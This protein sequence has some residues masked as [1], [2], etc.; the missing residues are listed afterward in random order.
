MS[1]PS[2]YLDY[3]PHFGIEN[4]DQVHQLPVPREI[5][6]ALAETIHRN[7]NIE[8]END[9]PKYRDM[10]WL[11]LGM[12]IF[13]VCLSIRFLSKVTRFSLATI[14]LTLIVIK[15]FMIMTSLPLKERLI[16]VFLAQVKFRT[17][18]VVSVKEV[19]EYRVKVKNKKGQMSIEEFETLVGFHFSVHKHNLKKFNKQSEAKGDSLLVHDNEE[20]V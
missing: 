18:G 5:R 14:V 7:L 13:I 11:L 1:K 17:H 15:I 10:F 3:D 20:N 12:L 6:T 9:R 2:I 19:F 8:I 4:P 16:P